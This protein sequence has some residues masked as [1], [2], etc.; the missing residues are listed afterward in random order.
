MVV[1]GQIFIKEFQI[2]CVNTLSKSWC[3]IPLV[4]NVDWTSKEWSVEQKGYNFTLEILGD[5]R[6]TS[7]VIGHIDT[8]YPLRCDERALYLVWYS[9]QNTTIPV[10]SWEKTLAKAK[11]RDILE[12]TWLDF[13]NA[14]IM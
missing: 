3:W 7:P 9:L 4:L 14:M 13:K 11:L 12:N 1:K 10:S 6:S 8:M 5:P 2:I